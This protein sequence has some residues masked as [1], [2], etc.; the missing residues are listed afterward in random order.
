ME[1]VL[2]QQLLWFAFS[3]AAMC[4]FVAT[5]HPLVRPAMQHSLKPG[6]GSLKTLEENEN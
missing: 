2:Q 4:S 3:P 6:T 1:T 5:G